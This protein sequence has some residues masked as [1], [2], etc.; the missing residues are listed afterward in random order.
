M[1]GPP[2]TERPSTSGQGPPGRIKGADGE[3]EGRGRQ[4][5]PHLPENVSE[6]FCDLSSRCSLLSP[7]SHLVSHSG[8]LGSLD[9]PSLGRGTQGNLRPQVPRSVQEEPGS[10]SASLACR[11][12]GDGG[13][14]TV[15]TVQC[16][17]GPAAP[18]PGAEDD[19]PATPH[20]GLCSSH[21]RP[22]LAAH[23]L[24][25][26]QQAPRLREA[27]PLLLLWLHSLDWL[28]TTT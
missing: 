4:S 24:P 19:T 20:K 9:R 8:D 27:H 23:A 5:R 2:C 14:H 10:G 16:T 26:Q 11:A 3:G 21:H 7:V 25:P 18:S 22:V 13:G 15:S 17:L 6:Y 28:P 1:A 12:L